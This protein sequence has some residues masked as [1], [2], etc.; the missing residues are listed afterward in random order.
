MELRRLIFACTCIIMIHT[1]IVTRSADSMLFRVLC[2]LISAENEAEPDSNENK[3]SKA[4]FKSGPDATTVK[5][6][7]SAP[8]L[9]SAPP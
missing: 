3:I 1:H 8:S 5:S 6:R 7:Q 9:P 2:E 4:R